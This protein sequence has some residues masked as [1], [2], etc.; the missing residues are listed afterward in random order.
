MIPIA[1][2]PPAGSVGNVPIEN[3]PQFII[4]LLFVTG[5][6]IA[7][8]F[9]IYGGIRWVLS[10]GDKTK[11][12]TARNHIVASIIG[13]VIIAASFLIFSLVFQILGARNPLTGVL[14]IPTLQNPF[15]PPPTPTSPP[16]TPTVTPSAITTSPTAKASAPTTT[17]TVAPTCKP[18]QKPVSKG[19]FASCR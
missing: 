9:L 11:V 13:L 8:A 6:V 16:T 14:C 2:T 4:T 5:I 18:G 3:I 15:C 1:I 19:G 12:E 10:G 7:V 17:L